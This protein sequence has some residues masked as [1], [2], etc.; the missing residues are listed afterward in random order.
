[1]KKPICISLILVMSSHRKNTLA[2][3]FAQSRALKIFLPL[4]LAVLVAA[5][6]APTRQMTPPPSI[7][8]RGKLPLKAAI[9][10]SASKQQKVWYPNKVLQGGIRRPVHV[11][12]V[13]A[14]TT[15][16][17][18]SLVFED[19]FIVE[20][21]QEVKSHH[22]RVI[23]DVRAAIDAPVEP[24]VLTA[25]VRVWARSSD[26][27]ILAQYED[28]GTY[29]HF[30]T[31]V[32]DGAVQRAFVAAFE[33]ITPRL[34]EDSGL[35]AYAMKPRPTAPASQMVKRPESQWATTRMLAETA[36]PEVTIENVLLSTNDDPQTP[37]STVRRGARLR[38][39]MCYRV[40]GADS[41]GQ[42]N[43]VE[44]RRIFFGGSLIAEK[45]DPNLKRNGT[46]TTFRFIPI[47]QQTSPGEYVL[48][49]AVMFGGK[50]VSKTFDF[51]IR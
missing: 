16:D 13:L 40:S 23:M 46:Y 8:K 39:V 18:M 34:L 12:R 30:W 14:Q 31:A 28:Q 1:M 6:A 27:E 24:P 37:V 38:M 33:Q 50:E 11:G 44:V 19:A 15:L 5:C 20:S 25:T 36:H 2:F 4:V 22:D 43:L 48:K 41:Q 32:D 35:R 10:F 47:P 51:R 7:S 3:D 45:K 17:A 49:G 9:L 26:G 29:N 42:I 21:I